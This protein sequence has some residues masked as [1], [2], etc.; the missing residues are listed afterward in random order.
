MTVTRFAP[1]PTGYLHLGH[2]FAAAEAAS[3]G[4]RFLLRIEDL[5]QGRAR[6]E[7]VTAIFEDL[8]WLGLNW[9]D[10]VLRQSARMDAYRD[11][12]AWLQKEELL[13]PCFCSRAEIED[14]IARAA[15]AP[16][17][18]NLQGPDGPLYPVT[19]QHLAYKDV[20]ARIAAGAVYS[21]RLDVAKAAKRAGPLT[22]R[23]HD[24]IIEVDPSRFGDLILAR[25]DVPAS[26][27]LAVVVD[28]AFQGVDLVTRGEDLLPAA[29]VQRLLQKLLGLPE[30]AYAHH[31]L[32]LDDQ[33]RKFSKRDQAVT[34]RALRQ[35]GAAPEAVLKRIGL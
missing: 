34:L 25:K 1:S 4:T 32:I 8:R 10:P 33:G 7:F 2:A 19:C 16:H 11:A 35:G 3:A 29:H 24:A 9:E 27:H 13:Y 30:P 6:E 17:S 15:E 18:D 20:V 28:D 23:E 14:E 12:L 31:R 21:L 22:L 5:D 26:Y